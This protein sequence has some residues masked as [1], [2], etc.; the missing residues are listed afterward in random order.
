MRYVKESTLLSRYAF[1]DV[2]TNEKRK[3][4]HEGFTPNGKNATV[5]VEGF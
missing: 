2:N 4:V 5:Y 1:E 3:K